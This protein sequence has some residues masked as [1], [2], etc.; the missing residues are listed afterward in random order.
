M[1][2]CTKKTGKKVENLNA[3]VRIKDGTYNITFLAPSDLK[4]LGETIFESKGLRGESEIL[5]PSF[6]DDI[7]VLIKEKGARQKSLIEGT[8]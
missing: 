2:C 8:L 3:F 5:L 1:Y 7:I 6:Q 4:V